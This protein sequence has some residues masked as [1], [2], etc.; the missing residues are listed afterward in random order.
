[1]YT[2]S[3]LTSFCYFFLLWQTLPSPPYQA[4]RQF[5]SREKEFFKFTSTRQLSSESAPGIKS[6]TRHWRVSEQPPLFLCWTW[7]CTRAPRQ[8]RPRP[9]TSLCC[10]VL[11]PLLPLGPCPA[12]QALLKLRCAASSLLAFWFD[13]KCGFW[14]QRTPPPQSAPS[15]LLCSLS[16]H[17]L[18]LNQVYA[19]WIQQPTNERFLTGRSWQNAEGLW[20]WVKK[21]QCHLYFSPTS[22]CNLAFSSVTNTGN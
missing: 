5:W 17:H 18:P 3:Y 7:G 21:R 8:A 12:S 2:L 4:R 22:N 11:S 1:M 15:S 6:E 16:L 13:L 14:L 9:H 10:S 20:T 19:C